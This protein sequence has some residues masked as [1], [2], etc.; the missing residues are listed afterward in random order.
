M[1][2]I[3]ESLK[4]LDV[5]ESPS[6]KLL[7]AL[8]PEAQTAKLPVLKLPRKWF[9]FW[10]LVTITIFLS[11]LVFA[12]LR[13]QELGAKISS[14]ETSFSFRL[15]QMV[16]RIEQVGKNLESLE[17]NNQT[18]VNKLD[19]LSGAV[20]DEEKIRG[21]IAE[22]QSK[23]NKLIE[24]RFNLLSKHLDSLEESVKENSPPPPSK[25]E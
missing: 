23:L 2:A 12:H 21:Q 13:Y 24:E 1:S 7:Q 19:R 5:K 16:D 8:S 9:V 20:A 17:A 18:V 25:E 3:F 15:G 10:P 4:K 22:E 11:F 14:Q 6:A